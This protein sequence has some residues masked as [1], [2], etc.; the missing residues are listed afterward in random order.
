MVIV[1]TS[2]R[3]RSLWGFFKLASMA[4]RITRQMQAAP[5]FRDFRKTG[6]GKLHFTLSAW[7]D[8]ATM[9]HFARSGAHLESMQRSRE[10]AAEIRTYTYYAD[11]LPAWPEAKRLLAEQG[12][13]LAFA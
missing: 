6:L 8:E 4:L 7:D 13:V 9:R 1:V 12:K 10:I 11:A 2:L 3:L 5:G